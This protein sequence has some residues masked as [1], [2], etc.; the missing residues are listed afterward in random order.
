VEVRVVDVHGLKALW[1]WLDARAGWLFLVGLGIV[2]AWN[3][4][5]WQQDRA[6]ALRL[7]AQKAEPV[8]LQATPKVSVLVAAWNEADMIRE[9]IES[10]LQLRYPSKELILCAGG[11]DGTY[12]IVCQYAGERVVVLEQRPGEGKQ[13]A[14]QRCFERATGELVSLTDADCVLDDESFARTVAPLLGDSE[15]VTTGMSRPLQGQQDSPFVI[16]Q[17]CVDAYA[18]GR[19]GKYVSGIKGTNCAIRREALEAT[20]RFQIDAP[21]GTDYH[22]SKRLLSAGY[23]I[24]Y[25]PESINET[26][27]SETFSSYVRRQSR[28]LRNLVVHGRRF[29]APG[30][31]W[32]SLRSSLVG[33]VMLLLPFSFFVV[34]RIGLY[35]W[36]LAFVHSLMAKARFFRFTELRHGARLNWR[37]AVFWP[38]FA[39]VDFVAWAMPLVD[40]LTPW[41][42]HR[43]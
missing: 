32:A 27:Y 30:E 10:F 17:W 14:L 25:V 38:V 2:V 42:R 37:G 43:W 40:Y 12:E 34:G 35:A 23:Q 21:T 24:R 28:W 22:L 31:V 9:H 26:E 41:R 33:L 16:Y 1:A 6:L 11:D 13:R 18:A 5:K 36:C 3:W 29:N 7:R 19:H 15:C 20:G 39:L 4:W 8:Q